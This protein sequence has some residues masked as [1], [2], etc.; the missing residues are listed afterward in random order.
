[1]CQLCQ[2]P[3]ASASTRWQIAGPDALG[4]VAAVAFE[5]ELALEGVV[6]R[7]DPLADAAERAEAR[8]FVVAVGADELGAERVS[9]ELLELGAGEAFVGDEDLLAVQQLAA[10]GAFEQRRGD[11]AF[12]LVGGRKQNAI[13]IPSGAHSR[14]SRRP[15]K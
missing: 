3:A 14:Y 7:L 15:Q 6:D 4:G 5:R 2:Q 1:M 8:L 10:G 11:L 13:G 12:G 9:D